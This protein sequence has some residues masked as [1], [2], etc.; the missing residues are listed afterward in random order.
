[1]LHVKRQLFCEIL[2]AY[3]FFFLTR[4]SL[5][6][7]C[8]ILFAALLIPFNYENKRLHCIEQRTIY[9]YA[10]IDQ[11]RARLKTCMCWRQTF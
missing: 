1:M 7:Y 6:H 8:D 5:W 10:P 9:R 3:L 11:W 4:T 2:F